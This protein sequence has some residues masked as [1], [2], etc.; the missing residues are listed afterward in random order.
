MSDAPLLDIVDATVYRGTRR[1]FDGLSLHIEQGEQLAVVGPNGAGKT[2]LLKLIN[3]EIYP[4]R[5]EHS[6][7]KVL[8]RSDWNVWA[9]RQ[10]IGLISDDLQ[11]RY[12]RTTTGLDVVV[13]GFFSSIGTH[14]QLARKVTAAK[15]ERAHAVMTE[16]GVADL[17]QVSLERMSTGE[18]RRCL[19]GRALVHDPS[20]LILDE[21]LT[22]LDLAAS[23]DY[24][25][26]IRQLIKKG[27]SIVL[28]THHFNEIPPDIDRVVLLRAGRIIADGSKRD[29]LT[30]ENLIATYGVPLC[31]AEVDGHFLAYPHLEDDEAS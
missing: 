5:S 23:F 6:W 24:L 12:R 9:L 14:G 19:L 20:T 27:R 8:G 26:R 16:L 31:V 7:V 30:E 25:T 13:S 15:R 3:R 17:A 11:V 10:H 28:V 21:P 4:V 18:Q 2:T 22:G 1:V 29:V